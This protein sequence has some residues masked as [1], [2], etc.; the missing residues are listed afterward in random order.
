MIEIRCDEAARATG[1]RLTA[2]GLIAADA[3]FPAV[4]TDSRTL[5]PGQA[6]FALTGERF[7]GHDF[8]DQAVAG[9]CSLA[10]ISE[11]DRA[12]ELAAAGVATLEVADTTGALQLLAHYLRRRW[13]GRVVGVTGS[14]G[15]TTTRAFCA[16]LLA[17]RYRVHSSPGNLNNQVGVPLS[18]LL[19]EHDHEVAVLEL[20][21]NQP[22]EI[23]RL[24]QV[25]APETG[26]LTNIAPVHLE[27][28]D[29]IEG[30]AA[31]KGELLGP[32]GTGTLVFNRDDELV[33]WLAES[34]DGPKVPFGVAA[35]CRV[36]IGDYVIDGPGAMRAC[37]DID[38]DP[39][40]VELPFAGR[41]FLYNVAAAIGV[42][43]DHG[44][45][46]RQIESGI[47]ALEPLPG[48]GQT[49][50]VAG[51]SV[52]DDS[53][54]ANPRAIEALLDTVAQ[55][56]DRPRTTI[57]LGAMLELGP[58]SEK[59]HREVGRSAAGMAPELLVTVGDGAEAIAAG[60][61]AAGLARSKVHHFESADE[62]GEFVRSRAREGDL[63]VVKGSR[64]VGTE[65]VVAA[66]ER[67]S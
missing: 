43:L 41:P 54:N 33:R 36:R 66:L 65:A 55:V 21:M 44:L 18:L 37:F 64:G 17:E 47:A 30:I 1:G 45:S 4:S 19:L 39:L 58:D 46:R 50:V 34:F 53:Y 8:L 6:F 42:A 10:V 16:R 24:A 14:M 27:F 62:A 49:R 57:V 61:V 3:P 38:A 59:L 22:G 25:A 52:W 11:P 7:N 15:K 56:P 29:G 13:G 26:V 63:V 20:G 60:A 9:E 32:L 35:G 67:A 2:A 28:F 12:G 40:T 23:H 48:R 31:A 51:V 5:E